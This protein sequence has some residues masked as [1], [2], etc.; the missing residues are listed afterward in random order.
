MRC[1]S[2]IL[3]EEIGEPGENHQPYASH[4]ESLTCSELNQYLVL[5]Y[6]PSPLHVSAPK[7]QVIKWVYQC[8]SFLQK[9]HN[10]PFT[11]YRFQN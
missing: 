6:K 1:G 9:W 3:V 10:F 11:P 4:L 2:V 8:L 5:M 7:D